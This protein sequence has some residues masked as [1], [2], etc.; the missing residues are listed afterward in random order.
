MTV[1][2]YEEW[3]NLLRKLRKKSIQK[4]M[5]KLRKNLQYSYKFL[6]NSNHTSIYLSDMIRMQLPYG[7][8]GLVV[9]RIMAFLIVTRKNYLSKQEY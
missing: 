7:L 8:E 3:K 6:K 5:R 1:M 2:S 4:K 9:E